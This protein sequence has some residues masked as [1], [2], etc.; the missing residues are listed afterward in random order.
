MRNGMIWVLQAEHGYDY[1][2]SWV[3]ALQ[4]DDLL[5]AADRVFNQ[6]WHDHYAS[7]SSCDFGG[8]ANLNE[9][10]RNW[11]G[12]VNIS[13]YFTDPNSSY[14]LRVV[15]GAAIAEAAPEDTIRSSYDVRLM[16]L[17]ASAGLF[18]L[19]A[20]RQIRCNRKTRIYGEGNGGKSNTVVVELKTPSMLPPWQREKPVTQAPSYH[21]D[22]QQGVPSSGMSTLPTQLGGFAA[23]FVTRR[24]GYEPISVSTIF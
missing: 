23:S 14:Y 18:S 12:L 1:D 13:D 21:T 4:E 15:G 9:M 16:L 3:G 8:A 17:A 24:A 2:L 10:P 22:E 20:M 19:L 6:Y 7:G 11:T 5:A